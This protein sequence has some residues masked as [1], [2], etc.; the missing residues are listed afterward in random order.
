V[1]P[2]VPAAFDGFIESAT[3]PD[4]EMR[5]E[6]AAA[7]RLDLATFS[8]TLERART[9][10]SL[11]NDVP[12]V[13]RDPVSGEAT[14]AIPPAA[15][16]QSIPQ[17]GRHRRRRG[18]SLLIVL[19]ALLTVAVAAW[20][21]W[22]YVIPHSH[23]IPSVVGLPIDEA[24]QQLHDLGFTVQLGDGRFD[25]QP[26]GTVIGVDPPEGTS[27]REGETVT[28]TPSL[29]PP[30]VP[31]PNV[32]K[33]T[34]DAATSALRDVGFTVGS[35]KQVYSDVVLE[36]HV[37]RQEPADGKAPQGSAVDLWISKGHAPAA[38][39]AVVGKTQKVAEK[40]LRAAGFTPVVQV[41]F[42]NDIDRGDVISVDPPEAEMTSYGSPVTI[43]VSQGPETFPVPTLTGL[44]PAAAEAKAKEY[45]LDVSFFD[46]PGTAH[47]VVISQ[48]PTAGTIVRAGDTITLYVAG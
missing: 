45:G 3:D 32:T 8:A 43:V 28:L 20:G 9:L 47:T 25:A 17:V 30:P 14:A 4:R 44:T 2:T 6:S 38:V 42:S 12:R 1:T 37:V 46:V 15:I 18:R 39:P 24:S 40:V 27:L 13:V 19:I 35:I 10:A 5:P 16:T 33:D 21:G 36:G 31:V 29:G 22:S 26:K 48:I 23:A 41:A 11:V 34:Q 7:M